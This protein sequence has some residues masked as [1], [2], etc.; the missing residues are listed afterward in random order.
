VSALDDV[1]ASRLEALDA[2]LWDVYDK[3]VA[4][5]VTARNERLVKTDPVVIELTEACEA[6]IGLER[7]ILRAGTDAFRA[8]RIA[9]S[10]PAPRPQLRDM[11]LGEGKQK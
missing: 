2:A 3:A 5:S 1:F 11:D 10:P 8:G 7:A 6:V 9:A 4:V